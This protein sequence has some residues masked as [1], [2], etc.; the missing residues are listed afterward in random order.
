MLFKHK[1]ANRYLT[2]P[3]L[4]IIVLWIIASPLDKKTVYGVEA[5]PEFEASGVV[6]MDASS[7]YVIHGRNANARMPMA[8]TTKI[9]TAM[10]VLEQSRLDEVV[11]TPQEAKE[12][13]GTV[14]YLEPGETKTVEQLLY[15]ALLNSANDAAWTLAAHEGEG[16]VE[17]FVEMMNRRAKELGANNTNFTNPTGLSDP[18]HYSTPRDMALITRQA[19]NNQEFRKII[20]T[21]SRPWIGNLHQVNLYNLNRLLYNYPGITGVKTGYTSDAKN[22]LV[23]SAQRDG[24]EM[25]SVVLGCDSTIWENTARLLDYGLKNSTSL[26]VVQKDQA[27]AQLQLSRGRSID[28]LASRDLCVNAP[29]ANGLSIQTQAYVNQNLPAPMP[30]GTVAG[31]LNCTVGGQP[32]E[33][34]PLVTAAEVPAERYPTLP[35]LIGGFVGLGG[36]IFLGGRNWRK[37]KQ[38]RFSTDLKMSARR[39]DRHA[40]RSRYNDW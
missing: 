34:I 2:F 23:A 17:R 26:Q 39:A 37:K 14:V 3:L 33:P 4:L 6:L 35:V 29:E 12:Q 8:S 32:L 40:R 15:A 24:R 18:M 20:T 10:L 25:I 11:A 1:P 36:I 28:L 38:H 16:S 9:M 27:S 7:G 5:P 19:L 31:Y 22:C 21:K 13:D 30:A